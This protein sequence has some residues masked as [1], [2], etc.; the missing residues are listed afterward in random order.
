MAVKDKKYFWLKLKRDFFKRH[1][2][3]IIE[4][5]ENGKDYILF[6]LKLLCESVDHEGNLRFSDQVP[7]SEEMLSIITNTNVDI[8]RSAIKIFTELGMM[9]L[10]DD[11]TYFMSEVNK[12]IGSETY[13]AEQK[14]IQRKNEIKLLDN[15]Q[16]KS[17]ECQTCPSKSKRQS[18]SQSNKKREAFKTPSLDDVR[19]YCKER[20][21]KVDPESFVN[22]Y[23][24]K[25]WMVGKNKMKDWKAAVRTWEKR[26]KEKTSGFNNASGRDYDMNDLERKLIE[27]N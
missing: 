7:Y 2:I 27:T 21:N 3:R 24:S 19:S 22:F 20:G 17:N 23:E 9:D 25:G 12:M 1:D 18:K 14:R 16:S 11:G 13:W 26:D 6:Y 8:V 5:M 10:M 4:S 15:V